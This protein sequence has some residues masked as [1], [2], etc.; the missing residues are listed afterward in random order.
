M[1]T[2]SSHAPMQRSDPERRNAY[3]E[4]LIVHIELQL[5]RSVP[6]LELSHLA[7]VLGLAFLLSIQD[8][9]SSRASQLR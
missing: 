3:A 6:H 2:P 4:S 1:S 8:G 9:H 5:F 7:W